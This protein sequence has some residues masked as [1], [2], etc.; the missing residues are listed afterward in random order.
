MGTYST[1][2]TALSN[3]L[4]KV[5]HHAVDQNLGAA[6]Q[7]LAV[8]SR[9][10]TVCFQGESFTKA[11][12]ELLLKR[13]SPGWEHGELQHVR[14]QINRGI[15]MFG[16]TGIGET[17]V[18][19]NLQISLSALNCAISGNPFNGS[20]QLAF[21]IYLS[22]L[23]AYKRTYDAVVLIN[24]SLKLLRDLDIALEEE[25][26]GNSKKL[27]SHS[28]P[29]VARL[30]FLAGIFV[31]YTTLLAFAVAKV[32]ALVACKHSTWNITGGCVDFAG[33]SFED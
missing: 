19:L 15:L 6:L 1:L 4:N 24:C 12:F 30:R 7:T 26:L 11:R 10:A 5:E 25:E 32:V 27:K 22:L 29:V 13:K 18:Y 23:M 16:L 8:C 33:M 28:G 3:R 20:P 2:A 14:G 9:M 31:M 17:G 21:S